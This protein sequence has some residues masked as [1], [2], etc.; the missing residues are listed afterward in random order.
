MQPDGT[1]IAFFTEILVQRNGSLIFNIALKR[2]VDHGFSFLP[3]NGRIVAHRLFTL[4]IDNPVG[5]FTPDDREGIRD[6]GILFDTAVDPNNGNLY[7]VWQDS[8]FSRGVIDEIAFSMSRDGGRHWTR[9]VKINQTPNLSNQ[10]REAA[11]IPTIAV[12]ADGILAV[13][14]YDFRNDDSSGEL[15]DQFALFCNPASSNCSRARNWGQE[16]R[17]TDEPFDMLDAPVAPAA[18]GHFVGDYVGLESA[19]ADVHP[20]YGIADGLD[21]VS[22]FTRRLSIAPAVAV[23]ATD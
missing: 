3:T 20:A 2:S 11:F 8:R 15:T 7:L 10:F 9:P 14:Y 18:R 22:V 6:A 12:N 4:A 5:T 21:Q 16:K 23:A 17:L 1:V 19:S 13:T